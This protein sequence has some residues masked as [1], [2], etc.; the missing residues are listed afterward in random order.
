M[1][2]EDNNMDHLKFLIPVPWV[3]MTS[4]VSVTEYNKFITECNEH[5]LIV[6]NND[7]VDNPICFAALVM[8]SIIVIGVISLSC[9]TIIHSGIKIKNKLVS[10]YK[11][12]EL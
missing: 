11:K 12:F 5:A 7:N 10:S 1:D 3:I 2:N 8:E 6:K 4:I 9:A